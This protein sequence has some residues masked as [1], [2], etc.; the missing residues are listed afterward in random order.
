VNPSLNSCDYLYRGRLQG[1]PSMEDIVDAPIPRDRAARRM[2]PMPACASSP[3]A[4]PSIWRG[5]GF[6]SGSY[7]ACF[8]RAGARRFETGTGR[9]R[10]SAC[11]VDDLYGREGAMDAE[12]FRTRAHECR[13]LASI[14]SQPENRA[15]W[16]R[17]ASDWLKVAAL[18][19]K[20][21]AGLAKTR[22][23]LCE[24]DGFSRRL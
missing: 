10:T 6:F 15:F 7:R 2:A 19:E 9:V 4:R 8:D 3:S 21:R 18:A 16:L 22:R 1:I 23:V 11:P 5:L 12:T 20:H 17:L 13:Q 24:P 14:V